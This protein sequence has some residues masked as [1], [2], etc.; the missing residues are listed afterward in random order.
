MVEALEFKFRELTVKLE[1]VRKFSNNTV[2]DNFMP[3]DLHKMLTSKA[4]TVRTHK[5]QHQNM[6]CNIHQI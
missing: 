5:L 6:C 1:G 2:Y 4:I 3:I